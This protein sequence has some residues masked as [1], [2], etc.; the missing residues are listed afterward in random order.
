HLLRATTA[1]ERI[2]KLDRLLSSI[3]NRLD[4]LREAVYADLHK[5]EPEVL[6][7]SLMD[8]ATY[9]HSLFKKLYHDRWLV[10][11]SYKLFKSRIELEN[12]TGKSVEAV[13]QDFYARIFMLNL[14]SMLAFPVQ[15][16]I[17]TNH[18]DCKYSY[19]I[20]W[21]QALAKMKN[22]GILLFVREMIA[23]IIVKL[24]KLFLWSVVPIR[25]GRKFSRK[26]RFHQR[27][28]AFAY[29]PIS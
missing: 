27:R 11:E 2:Q 24:Q 29:K 15:D 3:E 22:V 20:S 7:T 25:P 5:H 1:E 19:Q 12:F 10:E 8:T 18:K 21:T 13:K 9:P 23:P 14:T 4:E 28:Y 16:L 17:N 26:S 6:I